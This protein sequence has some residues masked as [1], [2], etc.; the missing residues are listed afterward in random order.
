M[1]T[2]LGDLLVGTAFLMPKVPP[3]MVGAA[4]LLTL[5]AVGLA[6]RRAGSALA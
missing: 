3:R 2:P 1:L 4:V 5:V 6:M